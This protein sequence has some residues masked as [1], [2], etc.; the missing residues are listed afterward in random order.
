MKIYLAAAILVLCQAAA[1]TIYSDL[2]VFRSGNSVYSL[3]KLRDYSRYLKDF[4]CFYPESLTAVSFEKLTDP[5]RDYFELDT[6]KKRKGSEEFQKITRQFIGLIKMARYA[7]SQS[8]SV[9]SNLPKAFKLSAKKN[10]CSLRGFESEGSNLKDEMR[11]LALLE[12]FL[13]SRFVSE[14][15]EAL[16][17]KQRLSVLKNIRSLEESVKKQIEHELFEN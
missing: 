7:S 3:N 10:D 17:E 11:S 13:R 5:P 15:N 2:F 16:S 1:Q 14:N 12:I 8:V 9:S 4:K 6:F